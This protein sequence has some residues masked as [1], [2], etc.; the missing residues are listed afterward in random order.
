MCSRRL[1]RAPWLVADTKERN[2]FIEYPEG[3]NVDYLAETM[4]IHYCDQDLEPANFERVLDHPG[5]VAY[6][7]HGLQRAYLVYAPHL[8]HIEPFGHQ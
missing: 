6:H 2:S 7:L 3:S 1:L 5:M 8:R 4:G